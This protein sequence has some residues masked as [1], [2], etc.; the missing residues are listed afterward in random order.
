MNH[1]ACE[2]KLLS[3][4]HPC[5]LNWVAIGRTVVYY[6]RVALAFSAGIKCRHCMFIR[7]NITYPAAAVAAKYLTHAGGPSP[8]SLHS[9]NIYFQ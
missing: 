7:K 9:G 4:M 8:E 5:P 1:I 2:L 6:A 3:S